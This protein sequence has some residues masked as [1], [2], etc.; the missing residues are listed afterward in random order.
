MT[1]TELAPTKPTPRVRARAAALE[2]M[3]SL[4]AKTQVKGYP[5]DRGSKLGL[6]VRDPVT[7]LEGTC[8]IRVEMLSGNVQF[9][10]QPKG[11]GETLKEAHSLDYHLL[12]VIGEGVSA[13]VPPED[14][15]VTLKLGQR[16]RDRI[17][18]QV[19]IA[20][21]K[22]TFQNGCVYFSV[23]PRKGLIDIANEI[24][25]SNFLAHQRLRP[26]PTFGERLSG[27]F[28]PRKAT[29]PGRVLPKSATVIAM[30]APPKADPAPER[31]PTGGPSRSVKSMN[32]R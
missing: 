27:L 18:G 31:R 25:K 12:E 4:S 28:G 7:G 2:A 14:D 32:I 9:G 6:L 29:R 21:E 3:E 17:S 24:P 13:R 10:V 30:P 16:V 11:D 26:A 20:V 5:L 8:H 19:G 1:D 23:Q 15:T 22:A